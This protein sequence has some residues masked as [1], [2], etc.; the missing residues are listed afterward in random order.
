MVIALTGRPS[1][2]SMARVRQAAGTGVSTPPFRTSPPSAIPS[3]TVRAVPRDIRPDERKA[4][5]RRVADGC[6]GIECEHTA[7][8]PQL[9]G[10]CG[11]RVCATPGE[12]RA[13]APPGGLAGD[14]RPRVPGRPVDQEVGHRAGPRWL[15]Q[16][17]EPDV[18]VLHLAAV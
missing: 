15:L 6:R 9:P 1:P 17:L 10:E 11:H 5:T 16:L 8:E 18:P 7:R 2:K 3:R 13:Q 4:R 12:H 14:Q